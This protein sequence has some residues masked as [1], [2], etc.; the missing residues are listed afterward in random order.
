MR[1]KLVRYYTIASLIAFAVVTTALAWFY[2][3]AAIADLLSLQES[4]NIALTKTFANSIWLEFRP[5][6]AAAGGLGAEQLKSSAD[7]ARLRKAVLDLMKGLSVV[8]VKVFNLAGLTVFSTEAKQIGDD[9]S[10]NGGFLSA[11][12]G[13]PASELT[14][15]DTFSAFE[16]VVED[17][18]VISS[19]IPIHDARTGALE[20]VFEV[21]DDVTPF[22][23]QIKRT[24]WVIVAGSIAILGILYLALYFV[25]R[26]A[27]RVIDEQ[28]RQ[29]LEAE[30]QL[31]QSEKMASLGQMAAGVVHEL[32]T[33]IGFTRSNVAL[34]AERLADFDALF[35]TP[36]KGPQLVKAAGG[37]GVQPTPEDLQEVRELLEY[38]L[39]G[40]DQ[41]SDLVT[42][43]KDFVR[44]DRAKV[45]NVD[46]NKSLENVLRMA[47]HILKGRVTVEKLYGK[48]PAIEC[49][50]S[51]LNQ[52]LLNLITNAAQAIEDKGTIWLRTRQL[53]NEVEV[54]VQDNGK[55]IA[56]ENV[57]KIFEP[58]FTTKGVGQGTG[59]GLSIV[60]KI[61][62]QHG[63]RL[64][65]MSKQG[66]GTRFTIL[67]PLRQPGVALAAAA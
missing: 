37:A 49:M 42:N 35:A 27:D 64:D 62:E 19:Y 48:V 8:K 30:T 47:N 46:V 16:S 51:Q 9:K 23:A 14:H 32:N 25:V 20:G 12:A 11:R 41:M 1:F 33:P 2:R 31:V 61:I 67:L 40:L 45:D 63:G 57:G 24:Q 66:A 59:L 50:P 43:L 7:V 54:I 15:R 29:R 18:D 28:N 60:R 53:G 26:R 3:T 36:G 10:K 52:V 38:S 13:V 44:L 65:V 17:R 6:V 39:T 56:P 58:F 21:Y 5:F 22:L 34:A 55:G 4:K